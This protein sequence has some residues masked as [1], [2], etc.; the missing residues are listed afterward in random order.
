MKKLF[1]E[2]KNRETRRVFFESTI[3]PQRMIQGVGSRNEQAF[4][5][6]Y[7]TRR[8]ALKSFVVE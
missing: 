6:N 8:K 5:A 7:K 4:S 3:A 2:K 1:W